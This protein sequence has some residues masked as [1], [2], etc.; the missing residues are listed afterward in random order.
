MVSR[1]AT[2]LQ[3]FSRLPVVPLTLGSA[4]LMW[5]VSL[6]TPAPSPRT[7]TRYF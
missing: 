2:G 1:A 3:V 4:L 7:L 5:L 6:A